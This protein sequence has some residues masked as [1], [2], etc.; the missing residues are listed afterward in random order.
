MVLRADT[1]PRPLYAPT[2]VFRIYFQ[3]ILLRNLLITRVGVLEN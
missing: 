1:N 2:G 3:F